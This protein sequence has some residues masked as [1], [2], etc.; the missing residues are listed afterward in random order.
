MAIRGPQFESA[1]IGVDRFAN[2]PL[3]VLSAGTT[4]DLTATGSTTIYTVPSNRSLLVAGCLLQITTANTVSTD[5]TAS[6]G[7]SPS[8]DNL[9]NAE[10]LVETQGVND[11]W[12][13]W[14]DKTTL[15]MASA[16]ESIV[17]DVTVAAT[18]T[19]LNA[20]THLIGILY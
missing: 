6:L 13:F 3:S 4:V 17:V 12:S 2:T 18:A 5:A 7:I 11:V 15:L 14:S 9:F 16:G 20:A 19:Q 8:T 10:P 1:T